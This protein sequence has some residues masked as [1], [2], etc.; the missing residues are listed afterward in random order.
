MMTKQE[1]QAAYRTPYPA[2]VDP[3][4]TRARLVDYS[5]VSASDVDMNKVR[6]VAVERLVHACRVCRI[7]DGRACA[8]LIPGFGGVGTGASFVSNVEALSRRKLNLRVLHDAVEPDI[9]TRL[10]GL[11][12]SMPVL[13]A[14]VAGVGV[15]RIA[16]LSEQELA[17]AMVLGPASAGSVGMGGDGGDPEVFRCAVSAAARANGR[18]IAVIKPRQQRELLDRIAAARAAGVAAIGVDVDAAGLVNMALLGQKVEP[19]PPTLVRELVQAADDKPLI[20]KGIMTVE[21]ALIAADAGAAAIV[22]SNHGGRA[23]DHTPGTADVLPEIAEAVRGRLT[24]LADG[25]IR[26]GVD[27]LKMLALGADAVLVGRP[28]A[29][30][31]VGGGADAVRAQ[32]EALAAQLRVA[33]TLTGCASLKEVSP[34]VLWRG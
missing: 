18:A 27:V 19:K 5:M 16:G 20:L 28:L 6:A 22:V 24:I 25:G 11:D 4:Q 17:D 29:I 23:L 10:F 15:N 7:C 9:R 34:A 2:P 21:D 8:G 1:S 26:S 33:M 14:A 30:A 32:L 13:G 3:T 12:L 31:A